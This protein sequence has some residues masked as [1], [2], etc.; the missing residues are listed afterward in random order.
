[1]QFI[2]YCAESEKQNGCMAQNGVEKKKKKDS[3]R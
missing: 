3:V 2:E 1:M